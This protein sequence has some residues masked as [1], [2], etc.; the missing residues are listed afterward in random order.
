[1]EIFRTFDYKQFEKDISEIVNVD[2][3]VGFDAEELVLN[4]ENYLLTDGKHSY[5]LFESDMPGTCQGHYFF[6]KEC[7]GKKAIQTGQSMINWMFSNFTDIA[8]IAGA[9]P[10]ENKKALWMNKQLGFSH[11][12]S[13]QNEVGQLEIFVLT[14]KEHKKDE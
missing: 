7:R 2:E 11:A 3:L 12:G 5:A 6:S 13:I 8:V 1:M 10:K 9:T 4:P 14:K